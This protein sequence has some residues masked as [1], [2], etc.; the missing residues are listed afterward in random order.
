MIICA[1]SVS[2]VIQ[3]ILLKPNVVICALL[4]IKRLKLVK[5]V[6]MDT[7]LIQTLF[8]FHSFH[9]VKNIIFKLKNIYSLVKSV[10][11]IMLKITRPNHWKL[12]IVM[13]QFLTVKYKSEMPVNNVMMDLHYLQ[14]DT[15]YVF[16]WSQ[17]QIVLN[18]PINNVKSVRVDMYLTKI[19]NVLICVI[20]ILLDRAFLVKITI[21]F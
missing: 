21:K 9:I 13:F 16:V 4:I 1:K 2:Q 6:S 3:E 18:I 7:P 15:R 20:E 19:I 11:Q 12:N 10:L 8:V 17:N 14:M 5:N